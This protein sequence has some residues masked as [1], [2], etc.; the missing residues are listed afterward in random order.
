MQSSA[1]CPVSR[2]AGT[3]SMPKFESTWGVSE[4]LILPCN[5]YKCSI[6]GLVVTLIHACTCRASVS[7]PAQAGMMMQNLESSVSYYSSS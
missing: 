7:D 6:D 4:I 1:Y 3:C 2:E 5:Q